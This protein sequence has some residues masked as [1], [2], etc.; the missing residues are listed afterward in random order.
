ME[1]SLVRKDHPPETLAVSWGDAA[2]PDDCDLFSNRILFAF[3]KVFSVT[4]HAGPEFIKF[5]PVKDGWYTLLFGLILTGAGVFVL[6]AALRRREELERLIKERTSE[7]HDSEFVQRVM[8]DSLPVGVVIVDEQNQMIERVN[9]HALELF[10]GGA[11]RLLNRPCSDLLCPEAQGDCPACDQDRP[12]DYSE[13]DLLRVD[14]TRLP[15]LKTVKRITIKGRNKALECFVDV[16]ERKRAEE[17]LRRTNTALEKQTV[18]ANELASRAQAANA[19][20]SEFLANMSHEI[21]TPMNGVIGMTSL[22]LDTGLTEEQRRYAEVV[23]ASSESLLGIINDILDFSKIEAGKMELEVL[24]FDLHNLLEDFASSIAIRAYEKDLEL[25][26]I[27]DPQVPTALR[28]DPG[29]LR[30]IITN[31]AG[32]AIKFTQ[33]GEVAIRVALESEN[34]KEVLLRFSVQDTGIGIPD[35]KMGILLLSP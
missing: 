5:Y 19:A 17:Q 33:E 2:P 9:D 12:E 16:S 26:C 28:G 31:L 4:A 30:Q 15:V 34:D 25:L 3:G 8:L 35:D 7:F 21:R 18:L 14:G 10:G 32:N 22:L 27:A 24:D 1:L 29:R 11:D 20:K 23:R 13:T 6:S